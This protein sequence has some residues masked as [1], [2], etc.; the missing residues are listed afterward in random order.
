VSEGTLQP[1]P[2]LKTSG[3]RGGSFLIGLTLMVLF[4]DWLLG[5]RF[6]VGWSR[7]VLVMLLGFLFSI[8]YGRAWAKGNAPLPPKPAVLVPQAAV[9]QGEGGSTYVVV[10]PTGGPRGPWLRRQVRDLGALGWFFYTIFW[11]WPVLIGDAVLTLIWRGI[12]RLLGF[13][14]GSRIQRYDLRTLDDVDRPQDLPP[15]DQER[16]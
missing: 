3:W 9:Q 7:P 10:G 12:T 14:G 1:G 11:R 6:D 15:P 8:P 2:W 13:N 16:F 5:S 4:A